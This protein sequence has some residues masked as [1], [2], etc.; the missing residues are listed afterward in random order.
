MVEDLDRPGEVRLGTTQG[1]TWVR[2]IEIEKDLTDYTFTA[3]LSGNGIEPVPIALEVDSID[4]DAPRTTLRATIAAQRT[5]ALRHGVYRHHFSWRD[6]QNAVFCFLLG[7]F[8]IRE[9]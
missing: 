9:R 7:P 5:Q 3:A 4:P 6:P 8:E 1:N 2:T